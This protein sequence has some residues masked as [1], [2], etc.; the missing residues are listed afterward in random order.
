M[1]KTKIIQTL[2]LGA[3]VSHDYGYPLGSGLIKDVHDLI[4]E[5]AAEYSDV[6]VRAENLKKIGVSLRKIDGDSIDMFM[7]I[8]PEYHAVVTGMIGDV[9]MRREDHGEFYSFPT[10]NHPYKLLFREMQEYGFENFRLISFNYD[11]SLEEYFAGRLEET[12]KVS[13]VDEKLISEME[14]LKIEHIHG[15]LPLVPGEPNPKNQPVARYNPDRRDW[16]FFTHGQKNFTGFYEDKAV[17][18]TAL[19]YIKES[20]RIFFLG[21]S[22]SPE[23]MAILG[24]DFKKNPDGKHFAGTSLGVRPIPLSKIDEM[25]GGPR[26]INLK[27]KR[28]VG[29]FSDNYSLGSPW[30]RPVP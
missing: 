18:E 6:P 14:K 26:R 21:F 29:L 7:K 3:G 8:R 20:H 27:P 25:F 15:R 17:N 22:F 4:E 19:Q 11:R 23:N 10:E 9:L 1:A 5:R 12:L 2:I 16:D 13:R 24:Y 28:V 30:I